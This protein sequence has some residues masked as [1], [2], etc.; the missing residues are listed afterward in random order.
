MR[1]IL[2]FLCLS[3]ICKLTALAQLSGGFYNQNGYVYFVGQN[4]SG[5]VLR[6][7]TV[8]CVNSVLNQ[9]QSYSLC[10]LANRD[11]FSIGPENGWQWQPGEQLCVIYENGQSVYWIFQ[12]AP[13]YNIPYDDS[14]AESVSNN[15]VIQEKIRQLEWKI[16]D[17]E[18]SLHKYE[19]W[20]QKN[21]S[22]SGSQ[23][24]SSQRRL[25]RTYQDQIQDL[26]RQIR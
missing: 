20:N 15:L 1:C 24:I 25:I 3:A 2:L 26:I 17:A 16:R 21:P 22:I 9:Q 7:L 5:H 14:S 10:F 8:K 19:E 18:R 13:S 6:N 4:V 23:L 11:S 12:P